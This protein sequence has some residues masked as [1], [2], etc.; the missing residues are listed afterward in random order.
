MKKLSL[1]GLIEGL[2]DSFFELWLGACIS[3]SVHQHLPCALRHSQRG[4]L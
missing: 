3:F 4:R 2:G 1:W